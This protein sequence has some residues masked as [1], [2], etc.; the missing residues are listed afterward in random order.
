MI[1]LKN[2]IVMSVMAALAILVKI[3]Y[4]ILLNQ[5]IWLLVANLGYIL[6]TGG[7]VLAIG[8]PLWRTEKREDGTTY[9]IEYFNRHTRAVYGLE[10]YMMSA[11]ATGISMT[12]LLLFS[13]SKLTN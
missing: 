2:V 3:M 1:L 6:C 5:W 9:I 7:I 4:P 8:L 11:L 12:Y 10:G 13:L